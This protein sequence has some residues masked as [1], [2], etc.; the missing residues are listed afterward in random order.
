MEQ[1]KKHRHLAQFWINKRDGKLTEESREV[2]R[3]AILEMPDAGYMFTIEEKVDRFTSSRY[4]YYWAHVLETIFLTCGQM[5]TYFD[6]VKFSPIKN[7]EQLHEGLKMKFCPQIIMTPFGTYT[8][9]T[10]TTEMSDSEFINKFEEA[11]IA[12]FSY[13]PFGCDFMDRESWAQM[14]RDKRHPF[15]DAK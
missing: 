1:T 14:M 3:D 4:K 8:V 15:L 9:P 11:V 5:F 10:S 6:G 2:L 7:V 12:E 13:P